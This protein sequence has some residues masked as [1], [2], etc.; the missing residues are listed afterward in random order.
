[1]E[2]RSNSQD[3][4]D[5]ESELPLTDLRDLNEELAAMDKI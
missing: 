5:D 3:D 2:E 1:M 4:D